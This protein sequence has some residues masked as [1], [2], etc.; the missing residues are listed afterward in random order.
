MMEKNI[1]FRWVTISA[2]LN[3]L[4]AS[5]PLKQS[6]PPPENIHPCTCQTVTPKDNEIWVTCDKIESLQ[7]LTRSISA[8]KGH[9]IDKFRMTSSQIG[10]IPSNLFYQ[11]TISDIVIDSTE[12]NSFT[13]SEEH[14]F[15]GLENRLVSVSI[16]NCQLG[17]GIDWERFSKV[18]SL[19]YLDLSFNTF[20]TG[21]KESFRFS[22]PTLASLTL[23]GSNVESVADDAFARLLNVIFLDLSENKL[24]SLKRC[25]FPRDSK[26]KFLN[27]SNNRLSSLPNDIF[28]NMLHLK[29]IYLMYNRLQTFDELTWRP[30]IGTLEH[31]DIDNNPIVCDLSVCWSTK[32]DHPGHFYGKCSQPP[33]LRDRPLRSLNYWQVDNCTRPIVR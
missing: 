11:T 6:C 4:R 33:T 18:N 5:T 21:E 15:L 27:L 1:M 19:T 30:V 32:Y 7:K 12:I 26:I 8:L 24:K 29:R 23:K 22:H 17:T 31:L 9:A 28:S 10:F 14:P 20:K 3:I 2:L 13:Q 16:R 25:M